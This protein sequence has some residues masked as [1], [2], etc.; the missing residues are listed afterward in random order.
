MINKFLKL[1][2]YNINCFTFYNSVSIADDHVTNKEIISELK[3]EITELGEK[4]KKRKILQPSKKYIA[5]LKAQKEELEKEK[6]KRAKI[7]AVKE[8]IIKELEKLG[9]KTSI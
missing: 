2:A 3:K 5:V 1:I 9:E 6:A 4:P 7:D 8:E